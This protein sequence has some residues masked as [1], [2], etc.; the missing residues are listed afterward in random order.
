[1]LAVGR[2]RHRAGHRRSGIGEDR[3]Q[4][5]HTVG[6][7]RRTQYNV[8]RQ[9]RRRAPL[10]YGDVLRQLD[11]H[12][13][14]DEFAAAGWAGV[15]AVAP[16]VEGGVGV[17]RDP[18][19]GVGTLWAVNIRAEVTHGANGLRRPCAQAES[20]RQCISDVRSGA[21]GAATG[22]A[23]VGACFCVDGWLSGAALWEAAGGI[24][25][26][27]RPA[28]DGDEK[29]VEPSGS[30][31]LC[32]HDIGKEHVEPPHDWGMRACTQ[33]MGLSRSAPSRMDGIMGETRESVKRDLGVLG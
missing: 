17:S 9:H 27:W 13:A 25:A 28:K 12:L 21:A 11:Q 24:Q 6:R 7:K 1:M 15:L 2:D 30:G 32:L 10:R 20:F 19:R 4:R 26:G 31:H 29:Q 14:L 33:S 8:I 3:L 5:G 23:I 16:L 22:S 18:L